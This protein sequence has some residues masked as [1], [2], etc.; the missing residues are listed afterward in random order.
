MADA[1]VLRG[2]SGFDDSQLTATPDKVR[3]GKTFYGSGSD[4]IQT[5]TVTEIAAETVTLPLNGSYTIPQGIHSG[6]GK[7]VQ[8]LQTSSG[9][10]VYPTSEKRTLQT[11]NKY[12]TDDVYVAPLTGLKPENIKKGVTILG[13]TGTYEGYS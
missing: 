2:G 8:S 6:N 1:I 13:V 9:G 12:M 7:V 3:N 10:T 11:A 5:G 4:S